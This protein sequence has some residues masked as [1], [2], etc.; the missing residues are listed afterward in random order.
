MPI[1]V[2]NKQP[3]YQ[4]SQYRIAV[5]GEA[6]GEDEELLGEP[7]VGH[8]GKLLKSVLEDINLVPDQLFFGNVCQ[9]RP[10]SNDIT[11]FEFTGPE[12]TAGTEKLQADLQ[13]FK[14]N[15]LLVLGN[16]P[17]HIT[18]PWGTDANIGTWRGSLYWSEAFAVKCLAAFHPA[19]ILRVF[20]DLPLLRAD[21]QK[22]KRHS[23]NPALVLPERHF[24]TRP[25]VEDVC[26]LINEIR[27]SR[28][29]IYIDIE[30]WANNVG[31]TM[32]GIA[33]GPT[34]AFVIPFW[35]G[36]A[37]YWNETD[38]A[39]V[40]RE[41]AGL[42]ADKNVEKVLQNA[43]YEFFVLHWKHKIIINNIVGDTMLKHFELFP[44]MDKGL[45]LQAS[46]YT[47]QPYYKDQRGI[48][49][50]AELVYN[51]TDCVVTAECD[52]AQETLLKKIPR[53]AEHYR[54][55]TSL[56]PAINYMQLRGCRIDIARLHTHL[57]VVEKEIKTLQLELNNMVGREVNAKST[58]D[59]QWL[60]YDF[61][62]YKPYAKYGKTTKEEVLLRYYQKEHNHVLQVLIQLVA[63]RT[64]NSDIG[65]LT[66]NTDGRLRCS[67]NLVGTNTCRLSSS[68]SQALEPYFTKS[69]LLKWE[70]SGTNLQNQTKELRDVFIADVGSDFWQI[71]L[72]GADG[73]TVAADL[74]ALGA[75]TML[76]D[77]KAG[78]KPAKVLYLMLEAKERGEDPAK[79][80]NVSRQLLKQLTDGIKF[81]DDRDAEGRPGDWKYLCMKRVQHGTNYGMEAEKL[82][83]TIFKDSDG[84]IDLPRADAAVYQ[85]LYKLRYN[86]D[87]RTSWIERE[88]RDKGFIQTAAGFRRKF[89]AIRYGRPDP[90][91]VREALAF[92]PQCNTTYVCN[93]ALHNLWYDPVNRT[94]RNALFV[95]PLLQVHDALCGQF[96]AS[97][98]PWAIEQL[99]RWF[100]VPIIIHGIE[101][102]IPFSGGT[103][104]NW[105]DT[106][107]AL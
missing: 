60:L 54:F 66:T 65:K 103:G 35:V 25:N 49:G 85:W 1:L 4:P 11:S 105:K 7:F 10:P 15:I 26:R 13:V 83:A 8:S 86:P 75:S 2:P 16:T 14:P 62:G 52:E 58:P 72:E 69:G 30:G 88:L 96:G 5:V 19:Y 51:A 17:L 81:S 57:E 23:A 38:E 59:K 82:S 40:W 41:V 48:G 21:V 106:K 71:D 31:V 44:E 73:W 92:E 29:R 63:K 70:G 33:T 50:D 45:D 46:L 6:P 97:Y 67:Y 98:R 74:A 68:E 42:L 22:A 101:I 87:L 18:H 79:I 20:S 9:Q 80:N 91:V 56:L 64:R 102:T 39:I 77:Y 36:G 47:D 99:K 95:E 55:N 78:I 107:T 93:R 27:S 61:L 94:K 53:S 32:L 76:D 28:R 90:S 104:P 89:G 43:L 24:T 37:H 100:K 12:I 84:L 3:K 34:S